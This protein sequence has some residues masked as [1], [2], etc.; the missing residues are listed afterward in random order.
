MCNAWKLEHKLTQRKGWKPARSQ[1]HMSDAKRVAA[2]L[3]K[4]ESM[5]DFLGKDGIFAKLFG[6]ALEQIMEEELSD[7]LGYEPY[8][9]KS[10]Q[11]RQQP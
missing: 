10:E 4:A 1:D 9:A 8:K 7:P 5:D 2:E 11:Q 3:A 6:N